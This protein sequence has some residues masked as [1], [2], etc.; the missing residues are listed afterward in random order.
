MQHLRLYSYETA[1]QSLEFLV[2]AAADCKA[3][4]HFFGLVL[5]DQ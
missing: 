3:H 5:H 2:S 4:Q 1:P